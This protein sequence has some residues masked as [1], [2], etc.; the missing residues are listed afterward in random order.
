MEYLAGNVEAV[1]AAIAGTPNNTCGELSA[2][3]NAVNDTAVTGKIFGYGGAVGK[4]AL[5]AAVTGV[6]PV[7]LSEESAPSVV[8]DEPVVED[9]I[10]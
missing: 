3:N 5:K 1:K 6:A 7:A 8:S 4:T 10:I 2:V 9:E